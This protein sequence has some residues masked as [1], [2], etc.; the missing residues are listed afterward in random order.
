MS[1]VEEK[2]EAG[3]YEG[4]V[5]LLSGR[6]RTARE[7]S[8]LGISLLNTGRLEEAELAL[9]KASLLGDPEG[10]VELGNV[11]RLLGRFEEAAS[12]LQ[13]MAPGLSGEVLLR[14]LRWWGVAE[15]QAGQTAEG[16]RRV[17][18]AWHGYV[19][20]GNE[21]WTARVTVSLAQMYTLLGN[22]RRAKL[23]LSEAVG[24]LPTLPDPAP[25]LSALRNLLE[26]QIAHGEFAEARETLWEAKR[27][28][29]QADS[30][31]LRALLMTSEAELL[32]LN[33]DYPTY[34]HV[35]EELR[36]LAESLQDHNLRVWV[37]S[38]LA[39]HQSLVG[40]H[41]RAVDTLLGFGS[42]PAEWPAELWA[43][44]GVVARRR[45]DP[46][47]AVA[48]LERAAQMFREAGTS[49]ELVRVQLHHAAAA[50]QLR[51]EATVASAL[52]EALTHMLRL[53][54]LGE[55][56]PDLEELSE[57]LHYAVLEPEIAPYMEPLL[58]RLA[59]LAGAPTLPEDGVITVQVQTLGRQAVHKDGEEVRFTYGGTVPLLVYITLSPGRTRAEMQL[60]LFPEKDPKSG[61][62]YMR[63]CLKE[64][65]DR[66]GAQIVRFEGPHQA[67][68]YFLGRDVHVDLDL[69][70]LREALARRETA[71]ALAL[72]R[73]PFLPDLEDS[74]WAEGLR[75]E[76]LL[77]LTLELRR[78]MERVQA[79][80]DHRRVVL[81]ANQYLRIDPFESEVL[82]LR[83]RAAE[84][85]APPH[86]LAKY[87]ADL[88]R[89]FN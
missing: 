17:E 50:L 16:L 23:L 21:E 12:H 47:S 25:R 77:A 2:F 5:T 68:R 78:Q 54:Q 71:R 22:P 60:D 30:P 40:Q 74:E 64:L 58:D 33:G 20:L 36:P 62:A 67:P 66:L 42:V 18:R 81:L 72:Y 13:T 69:H 46:A 73:G 57:L 56:R 9:T 45:G 6:A 83:L 86:E 15:F 41:G 89:L 49:P 76:A 85:F 7:H 80:G 1:D 4:V 59:H 19:A 3:Q 55:F 37:V 8:L 35:L 63:Q 61:A 75:D 82:E 27:T 65:R 88:R 53:R 28:L 84:T 31:R 11:L 43:T 87:T 70:A 10:Q 51:Q 38:R 39:E 24:V 14:C 79:E 34:I 48:D 26:L 29:K 44:S 32:R 52:K